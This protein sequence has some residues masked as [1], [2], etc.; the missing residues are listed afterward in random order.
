ML[1]NYFKIAWRN[2]IRNKSFSAINI[3]GLAMGMACSLL[4]LLWVQDERSVGNFHENG[5]RLYILYERV[6]TDNKIDAGYYTPGVLANEMKRTIPEIEYAS[7]FAWE[8]D[9]PDR[10]TFEA[11]NKNILVRTE[12][13]KTKL[14]LAS[15]EKLYKQL[16]PKF[17][18][19]YSF[20][21]EEYQKL[22]KGEQVVSKLSDSFAFLGIFISC[23]G[24]L[25]LAMFTA[26]Q[27]IKE[28]G[29]RKVLGAT[30][31]SLFTLLSKEFFILIAIALV[32][33]SPL[34]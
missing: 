5:K 19:T 7:N 10:L 28:I 33:A 16:N 4:I 34:A 31:S 21:D 32:I 12:A 24:L 27:R 2:L 18:F 11:A 8:S 20:A 1:K 9:S 25:G 17:P 13:G 22:Y 29:I 6:Y 15:L 23:L 26:E 3:V 30:V 14:A